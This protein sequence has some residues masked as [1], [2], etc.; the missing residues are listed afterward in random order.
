MLNVQNVYVIWRV[1]T[2]QLDG[3]RRRTWCFLNL[4]WFSAF[5][6][7]NNMKYVCDNKFTEPKLSK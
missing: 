5:D 4:N 2:K 3:V 1:A 7:I 6:F